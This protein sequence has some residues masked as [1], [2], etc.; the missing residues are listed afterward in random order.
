M[1]EWTPPT[2]AE[3]VALTEGWAPTGH[4][5]RALDGASVWEIERGAQRRWIAE[6]LWRASKI[7]AKKLRREGE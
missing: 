4:V 5:K 6:I 1:S 3:T 7:A 2:D